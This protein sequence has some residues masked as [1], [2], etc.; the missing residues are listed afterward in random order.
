M[1]G[2]GRIHNFLMIVRAILGSK[3]NSVAEI[4]GHMMIYRLCFI[5]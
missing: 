3:P 1:K 5:G 4:G 2:F